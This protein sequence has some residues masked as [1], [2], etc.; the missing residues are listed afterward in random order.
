MERF[1][2]LDFYIFTI[3][4][5]RI[6]WKKVEKCWYSVESKS[7]WKQVEKCWK[8]KC[9]LKTHK[10]TY[11]YTVSVSYIKGMFIC[12]YQKNHFFLIFR[13]LIWSCL[14]TVF[15]IFQHFS[16]FCKSQN[17]KIAFLRK[18]VESTLNNV[19]LSWKQSN[20]CIY[21]FTILYCLKRCWKSDEKCWK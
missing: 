15:N 17:W 8:C 10:I 20:S 12:I 7:C 2:F 14:N 9:C 4:N 18:C 19:D 11:N 16:T 21:L 13:H 5:G 3:R 6:I 1:S